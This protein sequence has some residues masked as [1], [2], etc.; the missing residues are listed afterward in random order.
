MTEKTEEDHPLDVGAAI[1]ALL[2]LSMAERIKALA[3]SEAYD[4]GRKIRYQWGDGTEF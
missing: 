2:R 3:A 4:R 1:E